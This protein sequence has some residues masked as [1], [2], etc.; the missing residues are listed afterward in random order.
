MKLTNY[1]SIP[2]PEY[3][4][5]H[6][7]N[8]LQNA[9]LIF[10][11]SWNP[12][13]PDVEKQIWIISHINVDKNIQ[14]QRITNRKKRISHYFIYIYG[15]NKFFVRFSPYTS[16]VMGMNSQYQ[17]EQARGSRFNH[18]SRS[19]H[20]PVKRI[21]SCNRIELLACASSHDVLYAAY[22]DEHRWREYRS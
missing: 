11:I 19:T 14:I 1:I 8:C 22:D 4:C 16:L 17:S 10:D 13:N 5:F 7:N 20:V 15:E 3:K 12:S 9:K 18:L 21:N 2:S 6:Y